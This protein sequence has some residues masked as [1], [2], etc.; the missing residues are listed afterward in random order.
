MENQRPK[1]QWFLKVLSKDCWPYLYW[2]G[3]WAF[4]KVSRLL[5][6]SSP[7]CEE[8]PSPLLLFVW[9]MARVSIPF[10]YPKCHDVKLV[11][12]LCPSLVNF[13][14]HP[15]LANWLQLW[16]E[17]S[18]ETLIWVMINKTLYINIWLMY[19]QWCDCYLLW[20]LLK[21]FVEHVLAFEH[22]HYM[23]ASLSYIGY[24]IIYKLLFCLL[25]IVDDQAKT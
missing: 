16:S 13:S 18:L 1:K 23:D 8:L 15:P 4:V 7:I 14:L 3:L 22:L 5:W 9:H 20:L 2:V 19:R 17:Y 6:S 11:V 12:I 21:W 10:L 25:D 24:L